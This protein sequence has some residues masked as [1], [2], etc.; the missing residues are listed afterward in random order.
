MIE[1]ENIENLDIDKYDD[2]E[3]YAKDRGCSVATLYLRLIKVS[4]NSFCRECP[5]PICTR[6]LGNADKRI[7][8]KAKLIRNIYYAC[9]KGYTTKQIAHK[10]QIKYYTCREVI[11]N[12]DRINKLLDDWQ[13]VIQ[14]QEKYN[15]VL[16]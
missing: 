2:C 13:E 10:F 15:A 3:D 9:D 16:V 4:K 1:N 8:K 11:N 12:R 7:I 14:T 6:D 5:F